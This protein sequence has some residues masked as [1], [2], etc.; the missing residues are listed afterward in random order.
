MTVCLQRCILLFWIPMKCL[1]T[2]QP[3]SFA[4]SRIKRTSVAK[5]KSLF[6]LHSCWFFYLSS[7]VLPQTFIT[8]ASIRLGYD[9]D[10]R[11]F[12]EAKVLARIIT[13]GSHPLENTIQGKLLTQ[14]GQS[15]N[16]A[17]NISLMD[18]IWYA[19]CWSFCTLHLQSWLII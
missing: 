5:L 12:L 7:Q 14:W 3:S 13:L 19:H 11:I 1:L 8:L 16:N 17:V 10:N 6:K 15:D 18:L 4:T 9:T 2:R